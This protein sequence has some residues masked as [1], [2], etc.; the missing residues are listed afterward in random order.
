MGTWRRSTWT[1]IASQKISHTPWSTMKRLQES[2]NYA[3]SSYMFIFIFFKYF[4]TNELNEVSLNEQLKHYFLICYHLYACIYMHLHRLV[5][6]NQ[7]TT[8]HFTLIQT[9][10][11]LPSLLPPPP[12][13]F[14]PAILPQPLQINLQNIDLRTM[15]VGWRWCTIAAAY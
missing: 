1:Q 2:M 15:G 3:W 12:S 6:K 9:S 5:K 10:D 8:K 7:T 13:S 11:A 14:H 4:I